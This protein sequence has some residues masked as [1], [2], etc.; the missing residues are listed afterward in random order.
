[1]RRAQRTFWS[2]LL[3]GLLV[4]APGPARADDATFTGSVSRT[5][6]QTH[7]FDVLSAG[8]IHAVLDWDTSANLDLFLHDPAGTRVASATTNKTKPERITHEATAV[9]TWELRVKAKSGSASYALDVSYPGASTSDLVAVDRADEA[10]IAQITRSYGTYVADLDGDGDHDFWY[11]RHSGSEMLVYDNDGSGHF[12]A[13]APGLFPVNDRHDCSFADVD[14]NG[15]LDAYCALGA[16]GGKR[17]TANELWLQQPEAGFVLAPDAWGATD[18]DGR[19]RK[20]A[21]F[22]VND[23]GLL[24]L[25]VGNYYPRPDEKPTPN[26]FYLQD[27]PGELRSAPEYGIDL[28]I[29]G[30]CAEPA[31]FDRDG[32]VDLMVCAHGTEGGLKLYRNDGGTGFTDVASALGVTG[33]WCD[34]M[35]ADLDVDGLLDIA[36]MNAGT[37]EVMLGQSDGTYATVFSMSMEKSGCRFGGGG[38]RIEAADVNADGFPDLYVLYSGYASGAYN[39]PDVFLVNDG[40][41]RGYARAA[42]P[43]TDLGSGFSVATIEADGDGRLEFLVTNGRGTLEGPIQLIDF[44]S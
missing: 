24:D 15:S 7:A 1:M 13:R 26:R 3:L 31:D 21:W 36:R 43:Q 14:R 11:N 2:A 33:R 19:G 17:S 6:S 8:T 5:V 38:D 41:A 20:P 16:S 25:F 9:G 29:G 40:T 42:I 37:F 18:P 30:Q 32:D 10:G 34:A 44:P 4:H 28:E 12:L 35:W 23:D 22:D 39:L 27:P